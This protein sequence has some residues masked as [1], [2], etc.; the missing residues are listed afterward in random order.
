MITNVKGNIQLL[1]IFRAIQ[2]EHPDLSH[3]E[4]CTIFGKYIFNILTDGE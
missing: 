4:K 3:D 2:N 1:L